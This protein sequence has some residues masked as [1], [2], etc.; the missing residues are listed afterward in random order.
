[1]PDFEPNAWE[2]AVIADLRANGGTPSAGP[3]KGHPLLIM[4]ATGAKSGQP[5]RSILTWSR[6]GNDY[7]VA[8]TAGGSDNEPLWVENL[9]VHPDVSVEVAGREFEATASMTEGAERDR[10][11]D[12]HVAALPW[13]G[14]YPSQT[15][16]VIPVIRLTPSA[17][18]G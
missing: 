12:Q 17:A 6:D 13:F 5:R 9:R 14:D 7:V 18:A 15:D 2:D 3:L 8:G 4:I 11:W 16:R 10:L 1:V